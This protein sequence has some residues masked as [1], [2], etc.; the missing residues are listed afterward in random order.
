MSTDGKASFVQYLLDDG[1]AQRARYRDYIVVF[2]AGDQQR[3][4]SSSTPIYIYRVKQS[5]DLFRIDGKK[6]YVRMYA[7]ILTG[8]LVILLGGAQMTSLSAL[9]SSSG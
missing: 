9:A 6:D 3:Y 8:S 7:W 1:E 5:L 4:T 2:N